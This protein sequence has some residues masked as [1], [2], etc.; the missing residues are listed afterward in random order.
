MSSIVAL[1]LCTLSGVLLGIAQPFLWLPFVDQVRP[2]QDYLGFFG[3]IGYAPWFF[4][5]AH[6]STKKV[7]GYS[8]F[9]ATVQFSI[10]LY[11][12]YI[13]I[14]VH[15]D[16]PPLKASFITV[17]LALILAF[18]TGIF[19]AMA[20]LAARRFQISIL[21]LL[22][23]G[24]TSVEYFRNYLI[25][26]GFPWG[27]VGYSIGRV[28][29][30]LQFASLFGVFGLVFLCCVVAALCAQGLRLGTKWFVPVSI[31]ITL[32]FAVYTFGFF[33]LKQPLS[34]EKT[35]RVALLQGNIAQ[36]TKRTQG[37]FP[38]EILAIYHRLHE[39]AVKEGA[40]I[41]VWPETAYPKRLNEHLASID[42]PSADHATTVMGVLVYGRDADDKKGYHYRNS[43][44]LVAPDGTIKN[45][46]DKSH[47][48]PFGEYVP[49]PM[50]DIVNKIVSGIGAFKRGNQF[51]LLGATL[52]DGSE[53]P[54]GVNI[55]YE[56]IFPEISRGLANQGAKLLV[57]AT[58]DAWYGVS[59]APYQHLLMY[60]LRS[61]ETGRPFLRATNSG[62]SAWVD[63]HGFVHK[64]TNLFEETIV[65][66]DVPLSVMPTFYNVIG[67]VVAKAC[68]IVLLLL[69]FAAV[70]RMT[71]L[72]HHREWLKL[73]FLLS[74]LLIAFLVYVY[75]SQR[76]FISDESAITKVVITAL[77]LLLMAKAAF[78]WP[79]KNKLVCALNVLLFVFL[80][81]FLASFATLYLAAA[82]VIPAFFYIVIFLRAL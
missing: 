28:P 81:W 48:V 50:T 45:R 52:K 56:G 43:A 76:Q 26:G 55:C 57:N 15:G 51:E 31:A 10:I 23:L 68:L 35:V 54:L 5:L 25:F 6:S 67:D 63:P 33:R 29:E 12:I 60:R 69:Y 79:I 16:V 22:P 78:L 41:I 7:F 61:V 82:L 19:L 62:V 77:I 4:V 17:L 34:S 47:L 58:N 73:G 40:E 70:F 20:S 80:A 13:A 66:D 3:L 37:H 14:H 49:W 32:V 64:P 74:V 46:F 11:W 27:N 65:V 18:K 71:N 9:A 24:I 36:E 1:F 42:L 2:C 30:F 72:F 38:E 39:Q 75:F 44:F 8:I 59:S 21:W 53:I